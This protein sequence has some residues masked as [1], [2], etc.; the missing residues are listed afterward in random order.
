MQRDILQMMTIDAVK[1][2]DESMPLFALLIYKIIMSPLLIAAHP[3]HML[4]ML[5]DDMKI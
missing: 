2:V 3:Q 4:E 5:S 1:W